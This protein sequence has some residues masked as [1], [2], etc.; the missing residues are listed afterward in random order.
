MMDIHDP[1]VAYRRTGREKLLITAGAD[2]S[3][4]DSQG[5]GRLIE[6]LNI[7]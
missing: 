7:L 2:K 5:Q 1:A 6:D 4:L 3:K